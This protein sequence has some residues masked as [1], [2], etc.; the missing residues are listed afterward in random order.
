MHEVF[1]GLQNAANWNAMIDLVKDENGER[2]DD[3]AKIQAKTLLIWGEHDEAYGPEAFG[4]VFEEHIPDAELIVVEGAGHY[5][6]EQ[7][8]AL[9]A[10]KILAFHLEGRGD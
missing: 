3:L 7:E 2:Q 8:P 6:H 5:P 10:A 4:R 1:L 9:V